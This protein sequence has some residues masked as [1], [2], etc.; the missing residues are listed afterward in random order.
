MPP[1]TVYWPAKRLQWNMDRMDT[2]TLCMD[3]KYKGIWVMLPGGE[4]IILLTQHNQTILINCVRPWSQKLFLHNVFLTA[5]RIHSPFISDSDPYLLF[6]NHDC[7]LVYWSLY[8]YSTGQGYFEYT[9]QLLL[10][11]NSNIDLYTHEKKS[12]IRW[13]WNFPFYHHKSIT[14]SLSMHVEINEVSTLTH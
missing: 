12:E 10:F 5:P 9:R 2:K 7:P 6:I 14:L 11:R 3:Y 13:K 8:Y 1:W 4:H